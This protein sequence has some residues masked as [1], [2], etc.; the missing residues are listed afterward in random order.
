MKFLQ[1]LRFG[2]RCNRR[3]PLTVSQSNPRPTDRPTPDVTP[4]CHAPMSRSAL[5]LADGSIRGS[6]VM[7]I[8]SIVGSSKIGVDIISGGGEAAA[9]A[10]REAA[11]LR[12]PL[13]HSGVLLVF[14]KIKEK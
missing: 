8:G 10:G 9:A 4:R 2:I 14:R 3:L 6:I 12:L 13:R 1:T 11:P 7:S 5:D